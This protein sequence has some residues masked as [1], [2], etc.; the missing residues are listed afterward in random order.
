MPLL[1]IGTE[2]EEEEEVF[3]PKVDDAADAAVAVEETAT[4]GTEEALEIMAERE[5]RQRAFV[6]L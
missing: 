2:E 3:I 1:V 6:Q 5:L 4:C